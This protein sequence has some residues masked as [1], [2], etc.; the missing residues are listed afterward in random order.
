VPL[1]QPKT[2][3]E[4]KE[5]RF[6]ADESLLAE[7]SEYCRWAGIDDDYGHFF[8]EAAQL[9][10]EKDMGWKKAKKSR[11]KATPETAS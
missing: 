11:A 8:V 5:V 1:I 4:K 9:V 10:F 2:S 7:I 6:R 3:T